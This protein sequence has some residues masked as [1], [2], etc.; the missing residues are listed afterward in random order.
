MQELMYNFESLAEDSEYTLKD[1]D[2]L[3]TQA[4]AM[5]FQQATSLKENANML[6]STA[7]D[8]SMCND[9]NVIEKDSM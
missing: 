1:I 8:N 4:V 9:F 3:E 2:S 6:D 5:W 7:D